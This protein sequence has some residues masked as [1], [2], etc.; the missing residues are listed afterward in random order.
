LVDRFRIRLT[1]ILNVAQGAIRE[2]QNN[3]IIVNAALG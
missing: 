2:S 1:G 3:T